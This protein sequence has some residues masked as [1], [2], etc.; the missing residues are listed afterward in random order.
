M[1]SC[2]QL[3]FLAGNGPNAVVVMHFK[4]KRKSIKNSRKYDHFSEGSR[5]CGAFH[6]SW[7]LLQWITSLQL[8]NYP[9]Y[10]IIHPPLLKDSRSPRI[11]GMKEI[12]SQTGYLIIHP[13]P[14]WRTIWVWGGVDNYITRV[15]VSV[16]KKMTFFYTY[17]VRYSR[18][19]TPASESHSCLV[20]QLQL[21]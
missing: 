21:A 3:R 2:R 6:K 10:L 19:T 12:W 16:L 20:V 5:E 17:I 18:Y 7:V 8:F 1:I 4:K 14:Y 15:I 13:P 11:W 9:P